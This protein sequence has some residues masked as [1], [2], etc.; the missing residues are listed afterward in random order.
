MK[1]MLTMVTIL[2]FSLVLSGC[3]LLGDEQV[4]E[5]VDLLCVEDPDNELC[6]LETLKDLEEDEIL[7]FIDSVM[8]KAKEKANRTKCSS[9]IA[10]GS[11][12]LIEECSTDDFFFIPE[13][14]DTFNPVSIMVEGDYYVVVG[15]TDDSQEELSIKIKIVQVDGVYY[16]E[17]WMMILDTFTEGELGLERAKEFVKMFIMDY[18]DASITDDDFCALY[19]VGPPYDDDCDGRAEFL[20]SGRRIEV[21]HLDEDSDNDSIDTKKVKVRAISIDEEGVSEGEMD[22]TFTVMLD[23][24]GNLKVTEIQSDGIDDDCN[25][26][27]EPNP[28]DTSTVDEL[29]RNFVASY[30]DPSVTNEELNEMYFRNMYLDF[31]EGREEELANGFMVEVKDTAHYMDSFFDIFLEIID[32]GEMYEQIL[33]IEVFSD[34]MGLYFR[35]D[36][37]IDNDCDGVEECYIDDY[38]EIEMIINNFFYSYGDL[39]IT[40]E[41]FFGMYYLMEFPS[42]FPMR[43]SILDGHVTVLKIMPTYDSFF[44]IFVEVRTQNGVSEYR[45]EVRV[46]RIDMALVINDPIDEDCDNVCDDIL[47]PDEVLMYFDMFLNDFTNPEISDEVLLTEYNGDGFPDFLLARQD[48]I[49]GHVTVLKAMH[50][51]DSFFDI[52][53]EVQLQTGEVRHWTLEVRVNRIDMAIIVNDGV[54]DDCDGY[55]DFVKDPYEIEMIVLD[56]FN[57]WVDE[58]VSD[59]EIDAM[60]FMGMGADLFTARSL[61]FQ[62]YSVSVGSVEPMFDSF[63]DVEVILTNANGDMPFRYMIRVNRIDMAYFL[64]LQIYQDPMMPLMLTSEEAAVALDMYQ[65]KHNG[66]SIAIMDMCKTMVVPYQ[67]EMCAYDTGYLVS[68]GYILESYTFDFLDDYT[69][70]VS[71]EYV[72]EIDSFIDTYIVI[73]YEVDDM[74]LLEM[75]PYFEYSELDMVMDYL[76]EY[77]YMLNDPTYPQDMTCLFLSEI[78]LDE[79]NQLKSFLDA[80]QYMITEYTLYYDDMDMLVVDFVVTTNYGDVIG[81]VQYDI[82]LE[83]QANGDNLLYTEQGTRATNPMF[84]SNN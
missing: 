19:L 73:F 48:I 39:S 41:E 26:V 10:P 65:T 56:F 30:F 84:E 82:G 44:D 8:M 49:D 6:D 24:M 52:F 37:G 70:M 79:C 23:E 1:K 18:H 22:I 40:D 4:Q 21:L 75:Y 20:E 35:F 47:N 67:V 42:T 77:V 81:N 51:H 7:D 25:G 80:N 64:E 27:C 69:Y 5:Q 16:V 66:M 36:E 74:I 17:D 11:T 32:E 45:L 59:E 28:I 60:F 54:D 13:G 57:M 58:T 46:N 2:V 78:S 34:E 9:L 83:V 55:C 50:S 38:N 71:F 43:S 14:V 76:S 63:F 68:E 3:D 33:R 15:T 12:G 31:F 61:M 29:F 62:G 53:V 72:N